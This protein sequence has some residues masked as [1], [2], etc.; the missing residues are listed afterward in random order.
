MRGSTCLDVEVLP[1]PGETSKSKPAEGAR[2]APIAADEERVEAGSKVEWSW[3]DL[4]E[5]L[6]SMAKEASA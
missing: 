1:P 4:C 6:V 3:L 2:V 5:T